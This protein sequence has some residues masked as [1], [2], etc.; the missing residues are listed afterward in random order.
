MNTQ[1]QHSVRHIECK[2][3]HNSPG[4]HSPGQL[5]QHRTPRESLQLASTLT[6]WTSRQARPPKKKSDYGCARGHHRRCL[7]IHHKH[8]RLRIRSRCHNLR[9][10]NFRRIRR[11]R[12]ASSGATSIDLGA[13]QRCSDAKDDRG[14]RTDPGRRNRRTMCRTPRI[15]SAGATRS[16]LRPRLIQD[17]RMSLRLV[18]CIAIASQ[19]ENKAEAGM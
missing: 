19:L 9:R 3:F 6:G 15:E 2:V 18:R 14:T 1:R 13:T 11:D 10:R 4:I 8:R 16:T 7:H 12:R 17:D 5:I